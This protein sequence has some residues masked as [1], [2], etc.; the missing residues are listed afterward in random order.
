MSSG[1]RPRIGAMH[2]RAPRTLAIVAAALAC[3]VPGRAAAA[4]PLDAT[5]LAP[6]QVGAGYHLLERQGGRGLQTPTMDLC[7]FRFPS[8]G[9]RTGRVQVNYARSASLPA[10]S[11]EVVSYRRGR[12]LQAL[13]EVR[14]AI[15][16]C[17]KK[18]VPNPSGSGPPITFRVTSLPTRG[19]LPGSIAFRVVVS[20]TV[21]GV[22][23]TETVV[24]VYQVRSDVLS[25][26][27]AY[28]AASTTAAALKSFAFRAAKASARRLG[29]VA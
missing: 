17:P 2:V 1:R 7:G 16:Q 13:A 28:P 3:A 15:R 18:A 24:V 14:A 21:S 10:L 26:V 4:G 12:A 8:E 23:R 25:G 11:N 19:L 6:A 5:V 29:G 22:R 27:Y 20:A 9:L